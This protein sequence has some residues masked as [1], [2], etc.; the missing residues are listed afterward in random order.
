MAV[1]SGPGLIGAMCLGQVGNLLP[2]VVVPAVMTEHLMPLWGLS[3]AQAGL[4]AS[5]YTFSYMAA[6]PLLTTLT[7][8]I[9]A[10][11]MLVAGSALSGLA[12]IMFGLFAADLWSAT[13]IWGIAGI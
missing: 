5:A 9:D 3:A 10:R 8:R 4:M 13:L 7:D 11:L 6:V 1:L 12:T 2:P